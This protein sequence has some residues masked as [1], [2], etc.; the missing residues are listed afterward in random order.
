MKILFVNN[1]LTTFTKMDLNILQSC[2]EVRELSYVPGSPT[3]FLMSSLKAIRG[4]YWAEAVFSW[5]GSY[6]ALI[7]FLLARLFGR[8]CIVISS[9]YD[10]ACMPDIGYGNMRPGIHRYIGL[11]VFRMAHKVFAVSHSSAREATMHANVPPGKIEVI[12]HGVPITVRSEEFN[13][14]GKEP[15]VITVGNVERSNLKR[16]GLSNFVITAKYLPDLQFVVIGK[17]KDDAIDILRSES[18]A[19]VKYTDWITFEELQNYMRKASVYVQISAHEAFGMSL[20]EAMLHGC[21]P[22]VSDRGALPEV[23][24]DLGFVVPFGDSQATAVAVRKALSA[25]G[26][27]AMEVHRRI[28]NVFPLQKRH[29]HLLEA[30]QRVV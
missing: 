13:P 19:N 8:K 23:V 29:K 7:P 25:N 10:V 30:V 18:P 21:I 20:A 12:H 27:L 2:H 3:G 6:H 26:N 16:K 14:G 15:L 28:A 9:G 24:G 22:V 11:A 4:V 5:F 17:W 1:F